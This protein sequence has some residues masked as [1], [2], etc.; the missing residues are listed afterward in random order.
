MS[1]L[2]TEVIKLK[3][4]VFYNLPYHEKRMKMTVKTFYE[5]SVDLSEIYVPADKV[6]G[7][8]KCRI[9]YSN[10]IHTIEFLPYEFRQIQTM[11]I[12]CI[13][14]I[15]YDFKYYDRKKI[16]QL[17]GN[18]GCDEILIIKNGFVTDS[19]YSNLVFENNAGLFT[20]HT[21]LLNGTKRQFLLDKGL[22]Q[23]KNIRQV[24]I[25]QYDFVYLINA[26]IDLENQ[27]RISTSFIKE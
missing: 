16:N 21:Y 8:Y 26:M 24:D 5:Q 17:A 11:R 22:I 23:E 10:T 6:R 7:L 18:S 20:P 9:V 2:F 15:E 4:G 25:A 27:V 19:S 12:V 1:H 3:D 14:E 13:D